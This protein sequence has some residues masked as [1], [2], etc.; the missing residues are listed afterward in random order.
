MNL[1]FK[2]PHL[3]ISGFPE[4]GL[5]PL[6]IVIG[7]N[8][9]GKTH[10]LQA[11]RNGAI[12]NSIAQVGPRNGTQDPNFVRLISGAP[13]PISTSAPDTNTPD[14]PIR[15][16]TYQT[17]HHNQP[18][19]PL[20]ITDPMAHEFI[21]MKNALLDPQFTSLMQ[22]LNLPKET[23]GEKR[24][25][26]WSMSPSSLLEMGETSASI[27]QIEEIFED[28]AEALADPTPE[29]I[30][31]PIYLQG[32]Q[33]HILKRAKYCSD[34]FSTDILSVTPKQVSDTLQ[35]SV[36]P[37]NLDLP[38]L[39]G[40]YRDKFLQ[41]QLQRL[42]D[43]SNNEKQ[44]LSKSDFLTTFG[45]P[46]WEIFNDVLASFDLPYECLPPE[47]NSFAPVEFRLAIRG[48]STIVPTGN[49]S[50][51]E[52]ILLR[53]AAAS[54]GHGDGRLLTRL[55]KLLLLDEM[56]ASLHPEMV[57]RWLRAISGGLVNELGV[58][59]ILTT[60][61]PTTV[62]LA[63]EDALYEML[64]GNDGIQ[65][66]SKQS[67]INKLTFGVPTLSINYSGRRTVFAES[68]TDAEVFERLFTVSRH[69]LSCD[70][71]LNFISTGFRRKDAGE[72][73]SGSSAVKKIVRELNRSGNSD[74]YGIID[75]DGSSTSDGPVKVLS[76]G[77]RDGLENVVL[78]PLLVCLLLIKFRKPPE[79]IG[80]LSRFSSAGSLNDAELQKLADAVQYKV[81]AKEK[82]VLKSVRF[83]GGKNCNV[84]Q[85]YLEMDDHALE[86]SLA[87]AFPF[88]NRWVHGGRAKL[89]LG[90][91]DE[92]LTEF[93][94]LVPKEVEDLFTLIANDPPAE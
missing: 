48:S 84:A 9:S 86:G 12:T 79:G 49:L 57:K 40:R 4:I 37:F 93:P 43:E 75:W 2:R 53:F 77:I 39:F 45:R 51:G 27:E 56:D 94:E 62:A 23:F 19:G 38:S 20:A 92:V 1:K 28:A 64:G 89:V 87:K 16:H 76:E 25:E 47:L 61:S 30:Q 13:S 5:P 26:V 68:N 50:S 83:L 82:A 85:S 71:E 60:H 55:P 33:I 81:V 41:N 32:D 21:R 46:P 90:V 65:K 22:L 73:N 36:N 80:D 67:A 70:R 74:V 11:I 34:L 66:V 18:I 72:I 44:C 35:V 78:D 69:L 59:C 14:D 29:R 7:P 91:V 24:H 8:G 31:N 88:L 6:T 42:Q 52:R 54:F 63:P 3:S 10:F 17:T 15:E 58:N